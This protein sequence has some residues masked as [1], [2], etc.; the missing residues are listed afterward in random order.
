MKCK[1]QVLI[2]GMNFPR[3]KQCSHNAVMGQDKCSIHTEEAKEH[4]RQR[5]ME[6]SRKNMNRRTKMTIALYMAK[7]KLKEKS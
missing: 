4:R 2:R 3:Y 5:S 6:T 7:A 1:E